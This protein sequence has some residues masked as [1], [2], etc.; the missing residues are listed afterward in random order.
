MLNA[1]NTLEYYDDNV[2]TAD[3]TEYHNLSGSAPQIIDS[4]VNFVFRVTRKQERIVQI[5][6]I[7]IHEYPVEI[8]RKVIV[9]AIAQRDYVIASVRIFLR[10]FKNRVSVSN[11]RAT[12]S[13]FGSC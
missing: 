1:Y 11:P 6:R 8:I 13:T 4:A 5:R 9:N 3:A 2:A 12:T 10:V 7:T